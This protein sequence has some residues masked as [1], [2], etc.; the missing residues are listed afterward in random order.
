MN[1]RITSLMIFWL[2]CQ[3]LPYRRRSVE[4]ILRAFGASRSY[5]LEIAM[6]LS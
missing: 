1:A 4:R 3:T 5:A 2:K 6:S